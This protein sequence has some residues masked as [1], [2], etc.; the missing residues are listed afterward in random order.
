[1]ASFYGQGKGEEAAGVI[2][3]E[4][5]G[6]HAEIQDGSTVIQNMDR[7]IRGAAVDAIYSRRK[8]H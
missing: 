8:G 3:V 7:A 1:M 6:T 5:I 2:Y 4:T